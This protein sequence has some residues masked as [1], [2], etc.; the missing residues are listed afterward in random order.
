MKKGIYTKIKQ[1]REE[2]G[3]SQEFMAVQMK[4]SQGYYAKIE[5]GQKDLTFNKLVRISEIFNTRLYVLLKELN[6]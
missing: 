5:N 1:I 3:F 6:I 4:I 2:K